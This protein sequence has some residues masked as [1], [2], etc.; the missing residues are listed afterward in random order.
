MLILKQVT[1]E[2][3]MI[4]GALQT[5][6]EEACEDVMEETDEICPEGDTD[7]PIT[8]VVP[9]SP[10]NQGELHKNLPA[11][12]YKPSI[13]LKKKETSLTNK[14]QSDNPS[15]NIYI[16]PAVMLV[17]GNSEAKKSESFRINISE[18]PQ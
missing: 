8:F 6:N 4:C 1:L 5:L 13:N 18:S 7:V 11:I 3:Q 15:T 14:V 10:E 17:K 2:D 9:P 12:T 16:E